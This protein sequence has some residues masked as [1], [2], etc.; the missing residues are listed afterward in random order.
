MQNLQTNQLC[1]RKPAVAEPKPPHS[2]KLSKYPIVGTSCHR[3]TFPAQ[4]F[5][6]CFQVLL[7]PHTF[8]HKNR[9]LKWQQGCPYLLKYSAMEMTTTILEKSGLLKIVR[10]P[11]V[12]PCLTKDAVLQ[13]AQTPPE[14]LALSWQVSRRKSFLSSGVYRNS[15]STKWLKNKSPSQTADHI[16]QG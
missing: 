1:S 11:T 12:W 16:S 4:W 6:A 7:C 9:V 15:E 2:L 14:I 8:K 13:Q 10:N 5:Y 3:D